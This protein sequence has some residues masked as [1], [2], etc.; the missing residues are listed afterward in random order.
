M[1]NILNYNTDFCYFVFITQTH[2]LSHSV[3]SNLFLHNRVQLF[4][5]LYVQADQQ[6]VLELMI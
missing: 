3:L 6:P 4:Q 2:P 5:K 1:K